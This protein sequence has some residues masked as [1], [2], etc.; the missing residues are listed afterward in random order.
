MQTSVDFYCPDTHLAYD[1]DTLEQQGLGGGI[2]SRVR[3]GHALADLGHKVN[4]Y[5][6]CSEERALQGVN[7]VPF[8]NATELRGDVLIATTSGGNLDLST[9]QRLPSNAKL[10]ILMAHGVSKPLGIRNG[11]FDFLYALSNFMRR[12]SAKQWGFKALKDIFVSHRG[13]VQDETKTRKSATKRDAYQLGFIGH[14]SKGLDNA[15]GVLQRLHSNEKPFQL[16]V[17]GGPE[18]WG[19]RGDDDVDEYQVTFH[20]VVGQAKL[21]DALHSISFAIFIQSREEPFGLAVIEAMNAGCIVIASHVG[22]F[23]EIIDHEINGF[24]LSENLPETDQIAEAAEIVRDCTSDPLKLESLRLAAMAAP[25]SWATVALAWTQHWE[26]ALSGGSEFS[27][28]VKCNECN[29]P[30]VEFADGVHCT[31]CGNY[32]SYQHYD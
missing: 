29:S 22:A 2:T 27:S 7:Y 17:F 21:R 19:E 1:L 6:N 12:K 15:I 18:L 20:G 3:M 13:V 16:Q 23:P 28:D 31:L 11:Q 30:T 25:K 26:W 10:K 8:M 4:L 24:L 14:P 32:M 9:L 5:V